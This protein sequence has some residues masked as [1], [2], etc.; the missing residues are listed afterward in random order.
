MKNVNSNGLYDL[1]AKIILLGCFNV[2][3]VLIKQCFAQSNITPDNTLGGQSSQVIP[4]VNN[5]DGIPSELIE[6]G[7]QRGENLFHSFQEFNV[8]QGRGAYFVVPNNTIQ[9]IL[10][11]VTGSN[12]SSINGILGTISNRN[13]DSSNVNLFLINPNGIIF[14]RNASL[15][16]NGSFVGTTANALEFGERGLFSA[17][18]PQ[19]PSEL[20]TV[21][22]SAFCL[23]K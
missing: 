16:I 6:A 12:A 11:R 17:T 2:S 10:T 19:L 1:V 7:A 4:S 20:L 21:N 3:T 18:N 22:P 14:G 8:N 9:N 15:D 13:F 23:I 5:P